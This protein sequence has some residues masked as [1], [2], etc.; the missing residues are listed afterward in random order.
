MA[1]VEMDYKL[2]N[3]GLNRFKLFTHVFKKVD[4]YGR[5]LYSLG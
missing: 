5:G 3:F 4:V 2:Q 1:R